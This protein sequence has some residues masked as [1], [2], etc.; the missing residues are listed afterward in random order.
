MSAAEWHRVELLPCG[1]A[2]P[3][4]IMPRAFIFMRSRARLYPGRNVHPML[5]PKP[6]VAATNSFLDS[7]TPGQREKGAVQLAPAKDG[8]SR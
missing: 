5:K 2:V 7:L 1:L 4:T 6:F 3:A 8:H